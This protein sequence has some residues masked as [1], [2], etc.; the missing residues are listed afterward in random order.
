MFGTRSAGKIR[1]SIMKYWKNRR[2]VTR[3]I[4]AGRACMRKTAI[5]PENICLKKKFRERGVGP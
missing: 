2:T 3:G 4:T 5:Q 1:L